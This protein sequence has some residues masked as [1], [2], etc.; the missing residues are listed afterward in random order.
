LFP[1]ADVPAQ[2]GFERL[3]SEPFLSTILV[4]VNSLMNGAKDAYRRDDDLSDGPAFGPD[5]A[6]TAVTMFAAAA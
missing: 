4:A 1:S 3:T 5:I 6:S 2:A